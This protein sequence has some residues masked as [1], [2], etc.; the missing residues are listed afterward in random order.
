MRAKFLEEAIGK[1]DEDL[2]LLIVEAG[3]K[4]KKIIEADD[5]QGSIIPRPKPLGAYTG[6][7]T[8]EIYGDFKLAAEEE[9]LSVAAGPAAY[10]GKLTH[11]SNNTFMLSWASINSG[12]QKVTFTFNEEGK[13][14][15][16]STETLG[17]FFLKAESK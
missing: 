4:L 17:E 9:H 11:F 7:F 8:S 5:T 16:F 6:T 14:S 12:N 1:S 10:P 3:E 15:H 13:P 2:Q